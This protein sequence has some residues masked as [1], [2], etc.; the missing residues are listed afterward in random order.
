MLIGRHTAAQSAE[1]QSFSVHL[2]MCLRVGKERVH[3]FFPRYGAAD[4]R[5]Q[6]PTRGSAV[7]FRGESVRKNQPLIP[8]SN[9][10]GSWTRGGLQFYD[11]WPLA[12]N[13]KPS[14]EKYIVNLKSLAGDWSELV[15]DRLSASKQKQERGLSVSSYLLYSSLPE[16]I[17]RSQ[18]DGPRS[19]EE[20]EEKGA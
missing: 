11:V 3:V 5:A 2:L 14:I 12:S 8:R 4:G 17:N 6:E 16:S 7:K 19:A 1:I 18:D 15:C 9:V 13:S 20:E 10:A